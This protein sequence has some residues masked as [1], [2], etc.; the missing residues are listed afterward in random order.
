M[1]KRI[2]FTGIPEIPQKNIPAW[3]ANILGD[4]NSKAVTQSA[5]TL[6]GLNIQNMQQVSAKGNGF[7]ISGEKVASLD[8][9]AKLIIDVQT[10]ASDLKS[11]RDTLN[12]LI[13]QVKGK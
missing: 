3:E 7:T 11:T 13:Q 10:L 5:V 9:Y 1:P 12:A 4:N 8:D 6:P 2:R